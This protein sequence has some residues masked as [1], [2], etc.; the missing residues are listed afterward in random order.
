MPA[1]LQGVPETPLPEPFLGNYEISPVEP[2][3]DI[4]GH[5]SNI[6]EELTVSLMAEA[7]KEDKAN[8][9]FSFRKRNTEGS[10]G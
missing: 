7:K 3:Y 8:H 4:K 10:D 2:L 9:G 6:I 5:L 1:L